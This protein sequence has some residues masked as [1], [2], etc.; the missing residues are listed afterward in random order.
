MADITLEHE[1]TK[2]IRTQSENEKLVSKREGEAEGVQLATSASSF[3]ESLSDSLP[4]V[5]QRLKLYT[6]HKQLENKNE[7]T[8]FVSGG[9]ATTL[10]LSADD[11]GFN[12]NAAEL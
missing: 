2:L 10:F 6:M 12:L 5:D 4:D 1:R 11:I 8:K 9:K 7:R 3:M